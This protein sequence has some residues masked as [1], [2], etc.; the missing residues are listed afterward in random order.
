MPNM[1]EL[2]DRQRLVG[3]IVRDAITNSGMTYSD[4]ARRWPMSL[5]TLNRLMNSGI[6]G[7]RFYRTAELNLGLPRGLL[8]AIID[9]NVAAIKAMPATD[10]FDDQLRRYV[11]QEL[12]A[13]LPPPKRVRRKA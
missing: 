7:I 1:K 8:D 9:G 11:L 5:P 13:E 10:G 6:V 2:M 12:G 3:W 4:A